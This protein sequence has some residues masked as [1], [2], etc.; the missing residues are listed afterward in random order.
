MSWNDDPKGKGKF[1]NVKG[2]G[3][4]SD[5]RSGPYD[6]PSPAPTEAVRE[7][8][9]RVRLPGTVTPTIEAGGR[10]IPRPPAAPIEAIDVPELVP[11]ALSASAA[12]TRGTE[13]RVRNYD[14]NDLL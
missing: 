14:I 5:D 3:R 7:P 6:R 12:P 2:K 10:L 1:R 9:R 13:E 11:S 8:L 4:G